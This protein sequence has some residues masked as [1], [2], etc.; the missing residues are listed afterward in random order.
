[1]HYLNKINWLWTGWKNSQLLLY[2]LSTQPVI[3]PFL[4]N[5][6]TE[7]RYKKLLNQLKQE[8]ENLEV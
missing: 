1:M 2:K 3:D 7:K 8:C 4:K 6:Y 5:L